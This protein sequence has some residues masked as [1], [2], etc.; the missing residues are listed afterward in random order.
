[1]R[2]FLYLPGRQMERLIDAE[3]NVMRWEYDSRNRVIREI[4]GLGAIC[5]YTYDAESNILTKTR[6]DGLQLTWQYDSLSRLQSFTVPANG[7]VPGFSYSYQYDILDN[8]TQ[9]AGGGVTLDYTYDPISRRTGETQT[10]SGQATPL[11]YAHDLA[12]RLLTMTDPTGQSQFVYDGLDRLSSLTTPGSLTFGFGY[13]P[14]SRL[15]SLTR[16]NGIDTAFTYDPASQLLGIDHRD[17]ASSVATIGYTYDLV[18]NRTS[19]SRETGNTRT[20]AHDPV[21]RLLSVVNDLLPTNDE[22]FSYDHEG[23]WTIENRQHDAANQLEENDDYTFEY[24]AE[25]CLTRKVSKI[26]PTD[27]TLYHWDALNR[28]VEVSTPSFTVTYQYDPL[29]RRIERNAGGQITRYIYEGSN[30]LFEL[31]ATNTIT[32]INRHA[33]LDNLLVH[34]TGGQAYYPLRDGINSTVA[35]ADSSGSI[36]QRYRYSAFG[37]PEILNASGSPIP[38]AP[39]LTYLYTGR[40]WDA[41]VELNYHRNRYLSPDMGRWLS[42]DPIGLAGGLNLYGYVL[43]NPLTLIDPLGLDDMNLLP[44]ATAEERAFSER[45]DKSK[46]YKDDYTVAAH[47]RTGEVLDNHGNPISPEKMADLIKTDSNY[48]P[49]KPVRLIICQSGV[50]D[51]TTAGGGESYA[52]KLAREL[53][54][55]VYGATNVFDRTFRSEKPSLLRPKPSESIGA[56]WELSPAPGN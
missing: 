27:A 41:S 38:A 46:A 30:V 37:Q 53:N 6:R 18:G 32:A 29:G 7:A 52:D 5:E 31:D 50:K 16:P 36:T 40:E 10:H 2:Q 45:V 47:G 8:V 23:N 54:N 21:D 1:V 11:A 51:N 49:N 24:D 42:R 20:F 25:G 17:S 33:G 3:G 39:L 28:L 56:R 15:T 43:N 26:D 44:K 14:A 9:I 22:S 35:L 55:D 4:D 48:N 12:D 34:E 19:E 13:D